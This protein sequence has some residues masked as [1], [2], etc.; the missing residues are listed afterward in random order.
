MHGFIAEVAE[1]GIG[2]A[3]EQILG[4]A[5]KYV[6]INDNG[7]SDFVRDGIEITAK[8]CKFWQ[9]F[10]IICYQTTL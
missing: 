9:S 8:V 2:N 3:R 6:W 10:I 4:E 7:P 5:P 1:C